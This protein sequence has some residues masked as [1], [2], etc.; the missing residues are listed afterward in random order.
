VEVF[1][2]GL[3]GEIT[4]EKQIV[5]PKDSIVKDT[6]GVNR[7]I[8]GTIAILPIQAS[9]AS[10]GLYHFTVKG[11]G[12][13][14]G[15]VV[16]HFADIHYEHLAT[17]HTH[18]AMQVPR[19]DLT[20]LPVP[21]VLFT[22]P[23]EVTLEAGRSSLLKV[24]VSRF[25]EARNTALVIKPKAVLPGVTVE[26]ARLDPQTRQ[27]TL[28]VAAL[29]ELRA[30]ELSLVLSAET[31]QEKNLGESSTIVIRIVTKTEQP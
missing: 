31:E 18:G 13:M 1:A 4:A 3:P 2:E 5:P 8:D 11:R 24:S 12:V 20:V 27:V 22:V 25:L 28:N 19:I 21:N 30:G 10:P 17:G 15:L 16:E 23:E 26:S 14:N 29:P 6:C 7:V 9:G